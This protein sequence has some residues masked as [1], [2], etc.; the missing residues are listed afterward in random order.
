MP[1]Y[2]NANGETLGR[3]SAII[4]N[5]RSQT[6]LCGSRQPECGKQKIRLIEIPISLLLLPTT[7]SPSLSSSVAGGDTH[8]QYKNRTS[9]NL[10]QIPCIAHSISFHIL[11]ADWEKNKKK[12]KVSQEIFKWNSA[13]LVIDYKLPLREEFLV[14]N[15]SPENNAHLPHWDKEVE[16]AKVNRL[17]WRA[18]STEVGRY[19]KKM[20]DRGMSTGMGDA[21]HRNFWEV[22]SDVPISTSHPALHKCLTWDT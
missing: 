14:V 21:W 9:L 18:F 12:N 22:T 19:H 8:E 5:S 7:L 11:K 4:A 20:H 2:W 6:C 15:C 13:L 3:F 17:L 16:V 10:I 1:P